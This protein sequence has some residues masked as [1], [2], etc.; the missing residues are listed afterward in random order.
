MSW[1]ARVFILSSTL[2]A[3]LFVLFVQLM[4][5]GTPG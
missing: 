4:Q 3:V 5:A 2:F 1:T